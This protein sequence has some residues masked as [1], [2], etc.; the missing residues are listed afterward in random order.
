LT[1]MAEAKASVPVVKK[2]RTPEVC[3]ALHIVKGALVKVFNTPLTTA[4]VFN[5]KTCGRIAV[6]Y[7]GDAP[8]QDLLKQVEDLAN[9]KVLENA[10]VHAVKMNRAEAEDKYRKAP[11]NGTYIYDKY[12][13]LPETITEVGLVLIDNWNVNGCPGDHL[14]STGGVGAIKVPRFNHR[15]Q[16]QELEFVVE[17]TPGTAPSAPAASSSSSSSSSSAGAKK[18][19]ATESVIRKASPHAD[20]HKVT[21]DIVKDFFARLYKELEGNK[22]ALEA[23][24]QKEQGLTES[25]SHS[26]ETTLCLMRNAAYTSGFTAHVP[27]SN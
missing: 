7:E 15:P 19:A 4:V 24:Q 22:E 18:E 23:V 8:S 10:P 17:I 26:V 25:F 2:N 13:K 9:E 21:N 16:K 1:E 27:K 6:H 5:N 11:V 20:V 3:T 14:P 12:A